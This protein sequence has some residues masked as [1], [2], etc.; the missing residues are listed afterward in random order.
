MKFFNWSS[1]KRIVRATAT[2]KIKNEQE[3]RDYL[4]SLLFFC[5]SAGV[6]IRSIR[7]ML[8]QDRSLSQ[9]TYSFLGECLKGLSDAVRLFPEYER[10]QIAN[11]IYNFITEGIMDIPKGN[12][13]GIPVDSAIKGRN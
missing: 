10:E 5:S 2:D 13:G 9:S 12:P 4:Y 11:F 1:L 6:Q 8:N 7:N 3:L